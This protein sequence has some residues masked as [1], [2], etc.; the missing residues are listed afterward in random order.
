M[1]LE[2]NGVPQLEVY[3]IVSL[4]KLSAYQICVTAQMK[5]LHWQFQSWVVGLQNCEGIFRYSYWLP[6]NLY[7]KF[8]DQNFTYMQLCRFSSLYSH[9]S[10]E[11]LVSDQILGQ[12]TPFSPYHLS[13]YHF[14]NYIDHTWDCRVYNFFHTFEFINLGMIKRLWADDSALVREG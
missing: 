7:V 8:A 6:C 12:T 11:N 5:P 4:S 3:N 13:T 9:C 2:R 1:L 10:S 14:K